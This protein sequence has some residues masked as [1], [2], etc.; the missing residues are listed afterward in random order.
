M[1]EYTGTNLYLTFGGTV[2]S[3]DYREFEPTEEVKMVDGSAGSDSATFM[4]A[5]LTKG[6]AKLKLVDQ[7]A[8]T[9]AWAALA[10]KTSGTLIWGEEGTA[11]GKPKHTV[12]AIVSDRKKKLQYDDITEIEVNF[13]FQ[14]AVSDSAY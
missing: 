12:V 7:A 8:G 5:T 3:A 11:S 9:V 1:A 4:Y 10:T 6:K 14:G 13:E 2:L